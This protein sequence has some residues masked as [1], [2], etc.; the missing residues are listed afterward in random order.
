MAG[1]KTRAM[2]IASGFPAS[3]APLRGVIYHDDRKPLARWLDLQLR[4]ALREA[5]HLFETPRARLS[6]IDRLRLMGW[7][8]PLLM[9]FYVIATAN[10]TSKLITPAICWP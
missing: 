1:T 8:A 7:L 2:A 9:F 4:Y 5:A 6:R 10:A 3:L